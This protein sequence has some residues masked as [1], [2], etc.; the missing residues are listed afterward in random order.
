M[1]LTTKGRY[2]LRASITL[3]TLGKGGGSIPISE[4][5]KAEGVSSIFLEQIFSRLR[6]AGIVNSARGPGG[7]FSFSCPLDKVTV[8]AILDASGE[9]LSASN[10]DKHNDECDRVGTCVTHAV[11]VE[12]T[13]MVNDYFRSL[14]LASLLERK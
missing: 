6:K 5:A 9:D 3:A 7:G 11:V 1:R 14:T 13:E 12:M 4:L 2:A 8:K 10:C